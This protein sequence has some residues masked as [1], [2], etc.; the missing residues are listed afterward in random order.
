[1]SDRRASIERRTAETTITMAKSTQ[2]IAEAVKWLNAN[3]QERFLS[4]DTVARQTIGVGSTPYR[5]RLRFA[6]FWFTRAEG[7]INSNTT[8]QLVCRHRYNAGS[9]L[10]PIGAYIVNGAAT[11]LPGS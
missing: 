8:M 5:H 3:P 11:M 1:M 9:G 6:G 2:G 7:A 10:A 4:I